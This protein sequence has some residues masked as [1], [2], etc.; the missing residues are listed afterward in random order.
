M[1]FVK[2]PSYLIKYLCS[3]YITT[4]LLNLRSLCLECYLSIFTLYSPG[5]SSFPCLI[6]I[7]DILSSLLTLE[8]LLS[9]C[10]LFDCQYIDLF[11][12]SRPSNLVFRPVGRR[13]SCSIHSYI[14]R[15]L[16]KLNHVYSW[17]L[18]TD[19]SFYFRLNLHRLITFNYVCWIYRNFILIY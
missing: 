1:Y 11:R 10:Q 9:S 16:A 15:T 3:C 8:L 12:L 18:L 17:F 13:P 19:P 14:Y 4:V 6:F 2:W 5:C 7:I